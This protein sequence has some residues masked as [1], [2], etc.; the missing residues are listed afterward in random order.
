MHVFSKN[1]LTT[2]SSYD[3]IN[4]LMCFEYSVYNINATD[5]DELLLL[6]VGRVL[7]PERGQ[8]QRPACHLKPGQ[9]ARLKPVGLIKNIF[10]HLKKVKG[11]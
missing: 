9:G 8:P 10:F 1:V 7:E 5:P 11:S 2:S 6:Y 3:I 4:V